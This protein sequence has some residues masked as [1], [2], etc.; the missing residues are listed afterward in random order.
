MTKT[1]TITIIGGRGSGKTCYLIAM[2]MIMNYGHTLDGFHLSTGHD[3]DNRFTELWHNLLT[4]TGNDRWPEKTSDPI[5]EF[6]F[7]LNCAYE[8]I[9]SFDWIDYRGGVLF[10]NYTSSEFSHIEDRVIESD[11]IFICVSSDNFDPNGDIEFSNYRDIAVNKVNNL[12]T[13]AVAEGNR[14][15]PPAVVIMITKSDIW[16]GKVEERKIINNIQETFPILFSKNSDWLVLIC[17]VSLGHEILEDDPRNRKNIKTKNLHVPILF[18]LYAEMLRE[19]CEYDR[20]V[21][22]IKDINILEENTKNIF[23]KIF[24]NWLTNDISIPNRNHNDLIDKINILNNSI[25]LLG[26]KLLKERSVYLFHRG[27]NLRLKKFF[28][29]L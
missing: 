7:D 24:Q 29:D 4:L 1:I 8:K 2:Y 5:I 10:D 23:S 9:I 15:I 20:D 28:S 25:K 12:I 13:T 3:I 11:C 27:K 14:N 22:K 19:I 17:P 16:E 18:T 6:D 21:K 26:K